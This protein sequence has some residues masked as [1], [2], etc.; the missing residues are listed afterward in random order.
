VEGLKCPICG[1]V[2]KNTGTLKKHIADHHLDIFL[3]GGSYRCPACGASGFETPKGVLYHAVSHR[4]LL[5]TLVHW[6]LASRSS[7]DVVGTVIWLLSTPEG[8]ERVK[9]LAERLQSEGYIPP[10]RKRL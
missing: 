2:F 5:H 6:M 3:D 9:E 7:S 10:R 8:R 1:R 4:D